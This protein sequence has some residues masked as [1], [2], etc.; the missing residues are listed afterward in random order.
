M[1][2][3]NITNIRNKISQTHSNI[4]NNEI[5]L[6][7]LLRDYIKE[8]DSLYDQKKS[9]FLQ[10]DDLYSQQSILH[11]E[12]ESAFKQKE[13]AY[14][15]LN[16]CKDNIE[17]WHAKSD[18]TPWLFGNGGKKLPKHS[19]FGQSFGDL[20]SYKYDRDDAYSDVKS[21]KN[22]IG[23]IKKKISLNK[24]YINKF[25][26]EIGSTNIIIKKCKDDRM[27]VYKFNKEGVD[28]GSTQRKIDKL[29][30]I[31]KSA[32]NKLGEIESTKNK[33][34]SMKKDEYGV[35][36]LER[37]VKITYSNKYQFIK[38]FDLN[39]NH[40]KRVNEHRTIW[41]KSNK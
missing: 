29:R 35:F 3:E 40:Q 12:L 1:F 18:R 28:K 39:E 24:G 20:D 25:K 8:L 16:E 9:L 37:E 4:S 36:A 30:S 14:D 15:L 11:E 41:T 34:I 27:K 17:S 26:N 10:K 38:D 22:K 7:L 2:K 21:C 31:L 19:L 32:K 33:Y 23:D 5:I 13:A 6:D